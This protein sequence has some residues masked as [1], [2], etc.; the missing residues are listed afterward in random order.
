VEGGGQVEGR[1]RDYCERGWEEG[2]M[3]TQDKRGSMTN[4]GHQEEEWQE[5]GMAT[6]FLRLPVVRFL[7]SLLLARTNG[8]T[9]LA[10]AAAVTASVQEWWVMLYLM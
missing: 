6:T 7:L 9:A 4:D 2:R 1:M 3:I 5:A 8:A 10:A